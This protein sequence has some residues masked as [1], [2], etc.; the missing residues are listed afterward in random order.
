MLLRRGQLCR[1]ARFIPGGV[2]GGWSLPPPQVYITHNSTCLVHYR[3][4]NK[5]VQTVVLHGGCCCLWY[6]VYNVNLYVFVPL[7][8]LLLLHLSFPVSL[9]PCPS[10]SEICIMLFHINYSCAVNAPMS[11]VLSEICL[12]CSFLGFM[13]PPAYTK[14]VSVLTSSLF[15]R[16]PES[17]D[18][19]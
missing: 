9:C 2:L 15:C 10:V 5:N 18:V 1:H 11:F 13:F 4:Q 14:S 3:L 8:T 16:N 6:S 7:H 17:K 19:F 12:L